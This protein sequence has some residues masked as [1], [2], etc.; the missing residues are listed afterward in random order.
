VQQVVFGSAVAM[1]GVWMD[2]VHGFR[3]QHLFMALFLLSPWVPLF[4]AE[5][6]LRKKTLMVSTV[7]FLLAVGA[8]M[9]IE[10]QPPYYFE[11]NGA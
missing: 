1:I 4:Y 6:S 2:R 3:V 11:M 5:V 10:N 7:L 9:Y 8:I